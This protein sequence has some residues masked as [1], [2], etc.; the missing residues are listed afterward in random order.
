MKQ[1]SEIDLSQKA[2]AEISNILLEITNDRQSKYWL[3][4]KYIRWGAV[5]KDL[6][7]IIDSILEESE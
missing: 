6:H 2:K 1:Q 3:D 5:E 7:A 4:G